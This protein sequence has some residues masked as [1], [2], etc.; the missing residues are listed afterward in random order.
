MLKIDKV[1]LG[2]V[3]WDQGLEA[4]EEEIRRSQVKIEKH[5]EYKNCRTQIGIY[6]RRERN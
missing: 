4:I 5:A 1:L 6:R 3:T 2:D